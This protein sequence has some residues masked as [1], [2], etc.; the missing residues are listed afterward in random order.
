M[1]V[2]AANSPVCG[3]DCLVSIV[4]THG[5]AQKLLNAT[6]SKGFVVVLA[7]HVSFS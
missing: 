3:T 2:G 1:A 4:L 5:L 7:Y 6:K